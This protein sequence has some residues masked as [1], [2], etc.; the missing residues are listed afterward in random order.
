ME[1]TVTKTLEVRLRQRYVI[2]IDM[3][4]DLDKPCCQ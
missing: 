2:D 3:Y 4:M 1:E